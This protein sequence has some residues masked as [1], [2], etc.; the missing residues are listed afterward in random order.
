M[1]VFAANRF[2]EACHK[3]FGYKI[4]MT[5]GQDGATF[6]LLSDFAVKFTDTFA[7]VRRRL[8]LRTLKPT[9]RRHSR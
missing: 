9:T 7:Q 8:G 1:T 2:R 6:S 4:E 3:I 5:E